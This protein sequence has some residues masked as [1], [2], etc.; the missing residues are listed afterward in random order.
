MLSFRIA[1][2]QEIS[3]CLRGREE[4][5]KSRQFKPLTVESGDDDGQDEQCQ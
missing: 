4:S 1:N 5:S 2:K 3:A